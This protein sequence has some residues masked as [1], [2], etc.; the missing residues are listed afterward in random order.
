MQ[1]YYVGVGATE[2]VNGVKRL[3]GRLD[4][5]ARG[6][7]RTRYALFVGVVASS[8]YL[9][10]GALLGGADLFGA[11]GMGVAFTALNFAFDP[12]DQT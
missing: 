8:G 6:L 4:G 2:R 5:W 3:Y 10:A 1:K 12:N 11:F 7:S 9:L